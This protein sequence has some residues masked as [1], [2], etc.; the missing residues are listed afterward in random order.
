MKRKR[1]FIV[2]VMQMKKECIVFMDFEKE[3][4]WVNDMAIGVESEKQ[5]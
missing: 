5:S 2:G 4:R 1:N 3:E